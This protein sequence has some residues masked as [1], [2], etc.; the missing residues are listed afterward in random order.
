M[1][2]GTV[3]GQLDATNLADDLADKFFH[4]KNPLY[5]G[6]AIAYAADAVVT[7]ICTFGLAAT[8]LPRTNPKGTQ[9]LLGGAD[10]AGGAAGVV[11]GYLQPL[12]GQIRDSGIRELNDMFY[13]ASNATRSA[14]EDLTDTIFSGGADINGKTVLDYLRGGG[15]L[16]NDAIPPLNDAEAF[17]KTSL[18]ARTVNELYRKNRVYIVST[19]ADPWTFQD[20][21]ENS[22]WTSPDS[23]R[24][25]VLYSYEGKKVKPPRGLDVLDGAY[26]NI[27]GGQLAKASGWAW[28][29]AGSNYTNE[30]SQQQLLESFDSNSNY[31]PFQEQA[32][33]QGM[34]TI[35]V[36]DVQERSEWVVPYGSHT[37]P[38][39]CGPDCRDTRAFIE[40]ANLNAAE[41][42]Y[43]RCRKQLKNTDLDFDNIDYGIDLGS[44][45][46]LFW[47]NLG[48]GGQI[49]F[50]IGCA[51][52]T[53]FILVILCMCCC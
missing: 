35:P 10:V 31:T 42:W 40:L 4:W 27:Y 23:G 25:F 29:I 20:Y 13:Y 34:S 26:Y 37:L 3:I 28:E 21:P 12:S 48:L 41:S 7:T 30:V 33:W 32:G 19:T 50:V 9:G 53:L 51:F 1:Y 46:H 45:I 39:C 36:C 44:P 5:L 43:Y 22:T 6:A 49:G 38:C 14:L 47:H 8:R 52:G 18:V 11:A 15:F 16:Y 24:T 2:D 17:Y